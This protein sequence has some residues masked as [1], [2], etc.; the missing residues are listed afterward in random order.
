[1]DDILSHSERVPRD[2]LRRLMVRGD[3][4][5]LAH[6]LASLGLLVTSGAAAAILAAHD[7]PW[8]PAATLAC[9]LAVVSFFPA[10]H[11]SAHGTAFAT[12]WLGRATT[13]FA[14][15]MMLQAPSFFREFH[16]EHHRQ[17]QDR[18]RDPEIALGGGLLGGWPKNPLLYLALVAGQ[19]L[20]LGKL[21]FTV[22]CALL[23]SAIWR[24]LFPWIRDSHARAVA[25]E[26]R[27]VLALLAAAAAAGLAYLPGFAAVLLAWPVAHVLLG[28]YLMPEH[29]G[30]PTDGSQL[31][32]TRTMAT[33]PAVRWWMWNMPYHGE[34]HAYP[35]VPFHAL[36]Q[37]HALLAPELEHASQGY[38][39]FHREALLRSLVG[40]T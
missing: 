40:R 33:T 27:L 11:E 12:P 29:T 32:R 1:M 7:D 26:S 20:M 15:L 18:A 3:G 6:V 4:P 24:R 10:L 14:S 36:P 21:M 23:P 35:A 2:A 17:T 8:W 39:A 28:F 38:L 13:W 19:G 9:A 22:A 37:L 31:H 16:W 30:L 34:H 25:W 5:G